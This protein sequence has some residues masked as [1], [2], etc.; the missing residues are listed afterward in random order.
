[1]NKRRHYIFKKMDKKTD[2][3]GAKSDPCRLRVREQIFQN[4]VLKNSKNLLKNIHNGDL[5]KKMSLQ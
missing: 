5:F 2:S 1:M 3:Q 4:I